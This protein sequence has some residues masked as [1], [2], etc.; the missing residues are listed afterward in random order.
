MTMARRFLLSLAVGL[1][2]ISVTVAFS[3]DA[4][5]RSVAA[6]VPDSS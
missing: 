4:A 2:L 3:L 6:A 5:D 1:A